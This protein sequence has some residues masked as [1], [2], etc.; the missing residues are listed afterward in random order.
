[1]TK[2]FD[3]SSFL[4]VTFVWAT[5]CW[6]NLLVL[7]NFR[8]SKFWKLNS[9][10]QNLN[11]F[12]FDKQSTELHAWSQWLQS[13]KRLCCW[14]TNNVGRHQLGTVSHS[15]SVATGHP[16]D[17]YLM[18]N[19]RT[20]LNENRTLCKAPRISLEKTL[21]SDYKATKYEFHISI[22]DW[23]TSSK[24]FLTVLVHVQLIFKI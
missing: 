11:F 4:R 18:N 7:L 3:E 1:M 9:R 6:S 20:S 22:Y 14:W 23:K 8:T 19:W 2:K 12:C 24:K 17:R 5:V 16:A 13:D 15:D 21:S 10:I